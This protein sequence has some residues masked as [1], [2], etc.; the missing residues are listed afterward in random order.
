MRSKNI[1][2]FENKL[3]DDI[4]V[5]SETNRLKY[6]PISKCKTIKPDLSLS[7]TQ[8]HVEKIIFSAVQYHVTAIYK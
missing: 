5:S 7:F 6:I 4:T 3:Y 2:A 1:F 8:R